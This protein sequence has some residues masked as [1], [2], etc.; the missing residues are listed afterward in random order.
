MDIEIKL[1]VFEGPLSLLLHLIDKNKVDIYDIPIALITDQYMEYIQNMNKENLDLISEFLVMAATLLEIKAKMLLPRDEEGQ[2]E[3]EDPRQELVA[4]LLEYKLYKEISYDLSKR[5]EDAELSFFR[6]PSLPKEVADYQE[7]VNLDALLDGVTL[8]KLQRV[9]EMVMRRQEDKIDPVRSK[10]GKIV[11]EPVKVSDKIRS[12]L[13]T[14][15][16]KSRFSFYS[17][18]EQQ[19]DRYEIVVTFLAVLELIKM[20]KIRMTQQEAFGEIDIEVSDRDLFV[21]LSE[22]NL[23]FGH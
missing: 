7:P 17:L 18:L 6:D 12:V 4:R 1:D 15:R 20:G 2:Q 22:E 19:K 9:F 10:F 23:E 14:C 13:E 16:K 11:N 5:E 21:E 3:E 8:T